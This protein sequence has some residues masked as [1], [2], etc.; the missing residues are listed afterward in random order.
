VPIVQVVAARRLFEA[1]VMVKDGSA[2]ERLA[3]ADCAAFDKTGTLTLGEP[4]LSNRDGIAPHFLELAAAL[5]AHSR[6]PLSRAIAAA[7]PDAAHSVRLESLVER[8]GE[9][10]EARAAEGA[11]RLGRAAW[12][13]ADGQ[14]SGT[15]LTLDGREVARFAFEDRLRPDAKLA[16]EAVRGR[17]GPVEMLSG[18]EEEAC[19]RVASALGIERYGYAML[20]AEKLARLAELSAAGHK[21]L[22]VGDG[23]NDAP[24]L[25]A[26]HVSM[27][28]ASAAD[29]GRN[30]ADFVFLRPSLNAVPLAIDVARRA[31][32]LVRQNIG[33]AIVYNVVAVPIAVLGHA[34]PLIA[35]IAMSLSSLLVIANALRLGRAGRDQAADARDAGEA[36]V[37]PA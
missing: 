31:G 16:V 27:A 22:M 28:P 20:P 11:V 33:L 17:L 29:V 4:R 25:A 7:A 24:S 34:T 10:I 37:V 12:A 15:V 32:V 5:G 26:A 35:A 23:L 2:M 3:E 30:A 8:P 9:G 14:G 19:R 21:P 6:H 36:A 13:R 18:D 1:G